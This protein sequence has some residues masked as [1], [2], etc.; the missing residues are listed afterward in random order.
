MK[1][2]CH[3]SSGFTL[4]ELLVSMVMFSVVSLGFISFISNTFRKL[5]LET[6]TSAA[7]QELKNAVNLLSN[8]FR[9]SAVVSPYLPGNTPATVTC[10]AARTVTS[11]SLRFLV[12]HDE[13]VS[14]GLHPYYV[15]YIYDAASRE[16]RRGEISSVAVTNCTL[17]VGDPTSATYA[18]VIARD[19]VQIDADGNGVLDPI[20]SLSGNQLTVNLKISLTG[21]GGW[22]SK[23]NVSARIFERK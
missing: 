21:P 2:V 23:Q 22:K 3:K 14:Y 11:T 1:R 13:S 9:I 12:S 6:R 4:I 17:P 5:S 10:S 19:V 8:E 7:A 15:G 16:L 20:F 18:T